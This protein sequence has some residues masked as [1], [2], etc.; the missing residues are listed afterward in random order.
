MTASWPMNVVLK[1]FSL[2]MDAGGN[3]GQVTFGLCS[4]GFMNFRLGS[5][6][7]SF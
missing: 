6:E 2:A 3:S 5:N 7:L 1:L 4:D